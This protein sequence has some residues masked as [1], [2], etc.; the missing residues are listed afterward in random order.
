MQNAIL[1]TCFCAAVLAA[2]QTQTKI[3]QT[4]ISRT[5]PVSGDAMF[6]AYCASC[7]GVDGRGNGPAA[8]ALKKQPTDLTLLAKNNGGTFP[9]VPVYVA[10]SGQFTIAAHGS[11]EMPVW[12][13]VFSRTSGD[14]DSKLRLTNLTKYVETIQRK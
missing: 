14:A 8:A 2:G 1:A 11:S 10:I 5:S 4:P 3:R 6:K 13:E 7:H 12:G 9:S